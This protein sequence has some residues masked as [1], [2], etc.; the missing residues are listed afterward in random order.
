MNYEPFTSIEN[1]TLAHFRHFSS[2]FTLSPLYICRER[3]TNQLLFMQNKP[4]FQ[5]DQMN[6]S[7]FIQE[8][9]E[10]KRNWTLGQNKPN[11]NPIKPNYQ[12][13]QMNVNSVITKDYRKKDDFEV[14]KNKPN[15]NP[16]SEK[17]K[18]NANLFAT[19]DYENEPPRPTRKNKSKQS[20]CQNPTPTQATKKLFCGNPALAPP[21]VVQIKVAN[22]RKRSWIER[23]MQTRWQPTSVCGNPAL[24]IPPAAQTKRKLKQRAWQSNLIPRFT[25]LMWDNI[26]SLM[27][28]R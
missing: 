2:L 23:T 20:Q 15:S 21:W 17:P 19:T 7:I 1:P 25:M 8:A 3:S 11:S 18:M 16:I 28:L 4:N 27:L 14:R 22:P 13:A 9:Y 5:D 6:V 26:D 12:K 24:G 10:N